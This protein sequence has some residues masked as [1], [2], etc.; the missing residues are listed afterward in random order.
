MQTQ[1]YKNIVETTLSEFNGHSI[2][3]L[4]FILEDFYKKKQDTLEKRNPENIDWFG[5][6]DLSI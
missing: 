1:T 4:E 5:L 3:G 6:S 2:Y